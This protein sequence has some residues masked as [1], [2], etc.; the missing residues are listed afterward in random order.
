MD[1]LAIKSP[2]AAAT[3]GRLLSS[4]LK[5]MPGAWISPTADELIALYRQRYRMA[6]NE[7]KYDTA[8]IFLNKILEI[9]PVN[10]E[11]KFCKGEIYHRHLADLPRALEQYQRVIRLAVGREDGEYTRLARNSMTEIIELLS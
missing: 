6:V 7:Q 3:R 4:L 1:R 5:H 2:A 9:D 11:A 8:L 10:V